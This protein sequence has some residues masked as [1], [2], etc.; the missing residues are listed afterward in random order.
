MVAPESERVRGR[1]HDLDQL[2]LPAV[3][4]RRCEVGGVLRSGGKTYEMTGIVE[5]LTPTP[6]SLVDPT[7]AR[8][9]LEGP[10]VVRLEYVRDCRNGADLDLLTLHWPQTD[11]RS[12]RL[13]GPDGA[14]AIAGGQHELW[15]QVR[16]DGDRLHG[17]MVSKRTGLKTSLEV[18]SDLA[19]IPAVQSLR[20]SLA[21]IDRIEIDAGFDGTWDNLDLNLQTNLTRTLQQATREALDY[22]IQASRA[23]LASRLQDVHRE[24]TQE[25][26]QWLTSR[27]D[28]A[29]SLLVSADQSIEEMRQK[30]LSEVGDADAY[31]G[32]LRSAIRGPLR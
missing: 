14:I 3:L 7:R 12:M 15:I 16:C 17:R 32:R 1:D 19:D 25:L 23:Q 8:L 9:R 11:A 20:S 30:V 24:Q 18:G 22:Q 31:L 21:A 26:H 10:E 27:Q 13:G 6:Q 29:R 5:N 2:D 4:V 28:E